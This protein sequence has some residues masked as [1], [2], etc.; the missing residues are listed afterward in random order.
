MGGGVGCGDR[1]GD[2]EGKLTGEG[3]S[4]GVFARKGTGL[5]PLS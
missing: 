3:A 2:M 4:D 1:P 5:N